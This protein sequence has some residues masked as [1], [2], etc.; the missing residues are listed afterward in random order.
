VARPRAQRSGGLTNTQIAELLAQEAEGAKYPLQRAFRKAGRSAFLWP[1]EATELVRQR[2]SLTELKAVGPF[3]ENLIK[4]WLKNPPTPPKADPLRREFF[5][6]PQAQ[7]ILNKYPDWRSVRGDL[8]MHTEWSDGSG[9]V[10]SM[11]EAAIERRYEYIAITDHAKKLKI[12]GGITEEELDEQG[13]EIDA[14]NEEFSDKEF[15]I[16]KSIELNLDTLGHGDMEPEALDKLDLVLAAFHSSL[17]KTE[18]QTERYLAALNNPHVYILGHPRGR[19]YNYRLGLK[20]DWP[21]VFE[22]AARLGK[23]VEID[24]YPD[25]QDLSFDLVKLARDAGVMIS[26][27]TD[28]HHPWQLEFIDFGLAAAAAAKVPKERILNFKPIHELLEWAEE[29]RTRSVSTL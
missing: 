27:G 24:C 15:R 1:I 11:A 26:L 7:E 21:R 28:A 5:T 8:Q 6:W 3:I 20:A 4:S 12:A 14:L 16:L 9:T 17:R 13:R 19:I 10:R 22:T 18:D 23:A 29:V 2:R 25:R